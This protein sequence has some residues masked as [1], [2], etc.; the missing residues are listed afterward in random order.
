MKKNQEELWKP[1]I[2]W[3]GTEKMW[4]KPVEAW[5]KNDTNHEAELE[6]KTDKKKEKKRAGTKLKKPWKEANNTFEED[7]DEPSRK[8]KLRTSIKTGLH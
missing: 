5:R 1:E 7:P 8:K 2:I 3:R 4:R 6:K